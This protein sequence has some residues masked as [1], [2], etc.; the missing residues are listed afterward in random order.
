MI[1][2]YQRNL[3]PFQCILSSDLYA[4]GTTSLLCQISFRLLSNL[5]CPLTFY[6]PDWK[7]TKGA[8]HIVTVN[9]R[10]QRKQPFQS[11]LR[12]WDR[13]EALSIKLV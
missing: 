6:M 12:L 10:K 2:L 1:K 11:F 9:V 7:I 13:Y 4:N 5:Y 8:K 3:W